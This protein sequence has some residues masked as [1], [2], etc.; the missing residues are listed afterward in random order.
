MKKLFS[1]VALAAF[2]ALSGCSSKLMDP[3]VSQQVTPQGEEASIT[4]FRSS[5]LGGMVQ[6]PIAEEI[7]LADLQLVGIC[8]TDTKVRHIVTPGQHIYVVGGE[9]GSLLEAEVAPGM[10]Y[11][12]RVTPRFGWAKARFEMVAVSPEELASPEVQ[13]EIRGCV[14][15]SPNKTAEKWFAENKKSMKDKWQTAK[16]KFQTREDTSKNILPSS[17]VVLELY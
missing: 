2:F 3:V 4:F 10:N 6:A 1:L 11:Y 17:Y 15:V 13:K 7:P 5:M 9:S 16:I 8:S 12:V 14:L